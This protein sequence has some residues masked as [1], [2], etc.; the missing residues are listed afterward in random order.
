[1]SNAKNSRR[2][3]LKK[4]AAAGAGFFIVPRNVLGGP[5]FIA[6]SDQLRIA[7]FGAGGKGYGDL[8]NAYNSGANR[9]VAL[10]DIDPKQAARAMADHPKAKFYHDYRVLLDKERIDAVTI[11]TPDHTHA[12]M[13]YD[14]MMQG[15]AVYVQKPLTHTIAE[16]RLLTETAS[17]QRVVT[18]MGNQGGSNQGVVKVKE[19]IDSGIVGEVKHVNVWTNRPVWPQGISMPEADEQALPEDVAWDLWLGPAS[20]R[21]Y[22]PNLHPFNWRGFWEYGTGALGDMGCHL[23]DA[24]YKALGLGYP[25]AV[26]ASVADVYS[27]MWTPD[28]T[29]EA[30]PISTRVTID[31]PG[32]VVFE[33]TDGG[34]QPALP[35]LLVENNFV[36]DSSG[37]MM[38]G[39]KGIITVDT[40]GNHPKLFIEGREVEHFDTDAQGNLDL[41]HN[42]SWTEAVKAGY[43]SDQHKALTSSFDYAGPFTETV[44]MGNIAIRAH[45]MRRQNENGRYD[46]FGRR[47][48]YWNGE[49][50]RITNLE[51]ANQFVT[52]PYREGWRRANL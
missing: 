52:K 33:W 48:L 16:A 41:I 50:M 21:P 40:Y 12:V 47:K 3:F 20:K 10:C 25:V 34:I 5:G 43:G 11:S 22:T 23:F 4:S 28:Y 31:F 9:I 8:T 19:W 7:A 46:Y 49:G 32:G 38:I 51:E 18:Q 27:R 15:K 17:E 45:Q 14:A 37:V 26:Q 39:S 30:C 44:L 29:P 2:D 36:P 24:P 13:T 35:D 1:M 6:P 42:S